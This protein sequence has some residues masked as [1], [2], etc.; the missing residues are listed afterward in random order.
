[1]AEK[2]AGRERRRWKGEGFCQ[3]ELMYSMCAETVISRGATASVSVM[4]QNDMF[5]FK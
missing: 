3:R 5:T 4:T 1:M 2:G